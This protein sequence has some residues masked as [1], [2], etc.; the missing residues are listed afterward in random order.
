MMQMDFGLR[1]EPTGLAEMQ[2]ACQHF[3]RFFHDF[4]FYPGCATAAEVKSA[5]ALPIEPD[6]F[7]EFFV[8]RRIYRIR[9]WM[10][11]FFLNL[12]EN[13]RFQD[14]NFTDSH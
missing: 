14:T 6:A 13:R 1:T 2:K 9:E 5:N 3:P 8:V 12:L 10:T 7:H 11:S 4:L